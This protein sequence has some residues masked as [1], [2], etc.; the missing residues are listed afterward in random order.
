MKKLL[1][2]FTALFFV[3]FLSAQ[4]KTFD[5]YVIAEGN[6]GTPNGDLFK[7]SR[8]DSLTLITSGGLYQT[9]NSTTGID[10]L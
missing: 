8:T 7:V 5:L 4:N 6:F 10:V 1:L 9:A 3:Q 2:V